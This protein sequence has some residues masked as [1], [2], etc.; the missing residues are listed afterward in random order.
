MAIKRR[1]FVFAI[2]VTALLG[3]SA[4]CTGR[5]SRVTV[6]NEEEETPPR[7]LSVVRMND[8]KANSQL[9]NGFYGIEND[10]WRWT[11][12]KFSVLL[13]TPAGAAQRGGTLT[14]AFNIPDV[15]IQKLKSVKLSASAGGQTLKSDTY[16]ASGSYTFTADVPP[17][18]LNTE[19]V[20]FDFALDKSIPPGA[21]RRELGII[22]TSVDLASK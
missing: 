17:A 7:M 14:L 4:G 9:L 16:T 2:P 3:A 22:V 12:G 21:D 13:E 20:R 19:S 5:H 18:A 8:R 11:A 15:V 6:Q 1:Y 10:A